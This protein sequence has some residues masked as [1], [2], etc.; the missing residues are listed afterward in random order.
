MYLLLFQF[1]PDMIESLERIWLEANLWKIQ[2]IS[3]EL[4]LNFVN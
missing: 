4:K 3:C 2:E 1:G